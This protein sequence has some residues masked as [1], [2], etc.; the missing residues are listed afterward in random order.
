MGEI[1]LLYQD[2]SSRV[3]FCFGIPGVEP[4]YGSFRVDEPGAP[5]G[6]FAAKY[7]QQCRVQ[8][9]ALRP[10]HFVYEAPFIDHNKTAID[11]A[12]KLL[13]LVVLAKMVAYQQGIGTVRKAENSTVA[14][15]FTGKGRWSNRAEKKQLTIRI[16]RALG[17]SPANDDEA[18]ALA[19]WSWS[20]HTLFPHLPQR[21]WEGAL[22]GIAAQ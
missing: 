14:K 5:V 17:W 3:G 21:R 9:I 2:L 4:E 8:M 20:E 13:G 7:V 11:T 16:C 18:D 22:L 10:T 12:E 15:Y 6:R 1:R 19:G